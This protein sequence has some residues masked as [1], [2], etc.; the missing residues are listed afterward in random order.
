MHGLPLRMELSQCLAGSLDSAA[1]DI[2]IRC[3]HAGRQLPSALLARLALK[4]A[5]PSTWLPERLV[6]MWYGIAAG[7][8]AAVSSRQAL[9]L[10]EGLWLSLHGAQHN[11]QLQG[12]ICNA[13]DLH[14]ST[15]GLLAAAWDIF[16]ACCLLQVWS[17][18]I[19][20]PTD[21][22]SQQKAPEHPY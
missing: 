22:Q 18:I 15:A 12:C 17:L 8:T 2:L 9:L 7:P 20:C 5:L 4:A 10:C 11:L 6:A 1:P 3:C 19:A 16:V 21:L 13:H 14:P